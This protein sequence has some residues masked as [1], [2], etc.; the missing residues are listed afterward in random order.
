MMA[1]SEHKE[2][3][4]KSVFQSNIEALKKKELPWN[5]FEKNMKEITN[6]SY[7]KSRCLMKLLLK[8]FKEKLA[9]TSGISSNRQSIKKSTHYQ[10]VSEDD[11]EDDFDHDEEDDKKEWKVKKIIDKHVDDHGK[12]NY[13]IVWEDSWQ[14]ERNLNCPERISEFEESRNQENLRFKRK[15]EQK[16]YDDASQ[17]PLKRSNWLTDPSLG[18]VF[19]IFISYFIFW[20]FDLTSFFLFVPI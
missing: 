16:P 8:E 1:T 12:V 18:V 17:I 3:K 13:K 6:G 2:D 11:S 15:S 5:L 19:Y 10:E 20:K 9:E 7:S 4:V 14:P